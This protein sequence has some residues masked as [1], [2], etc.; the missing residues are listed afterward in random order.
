MFL[1]LSDTMPELQRH[2]VITSSLIDCVQIFLQSF[3]NLMLLVFVQLILSQS[4]HNQVN[5]ILYQSDDQNNCL[6]LLPCLG[7]VSDGLTKRS[8]VFLKVRAEQEEMS[9]IYYGRHLKDKKI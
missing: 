9:L 4:G 5:I 3:P 2:I 6:S 1:L 8:I 7:T